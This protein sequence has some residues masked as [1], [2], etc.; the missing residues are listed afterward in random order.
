MVG[1]DKYRI[2][3]RG[4]RGEKQQKRKT[5]Q[6]GKKSGEVEAREEGG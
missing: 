1:V 3:G 6:R 4:K 5:G 2:K